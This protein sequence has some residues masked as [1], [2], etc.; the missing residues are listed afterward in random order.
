M[1][2]G[3]N[4]MKSPSKFVYV[5]L[6][7]LMAFTSIGHVGA[8]FADA[9]KEH[10]YAT[11][12]EML[13]MSDEASAAVRNAHAARL[14]L[15]NNETSLAKTEVD[16]AIASL[17]KAEATLNDKLIPD[18]S[19]ADTKPMYLPFDTNM[20]LAETYS[21]TPE[22]RVVLDK[23]TGL[24]QVGTPNEAIDVLR[25][26]GVEVKISTAMLPWETSQT[27]LTEAAKLIGESKFHEA[28][29]ALKAFEEGV[30]V[31]TFG[32]HDIPAQG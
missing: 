19:V 13:R 14:A 6:T 16:K 24:F 10:A 3:D 18:T 25:E 7:T 30:V 26:A 9:S 12:R 1:A 11:Q 29:V 15:F 22:I 28:N 20:A 17:A 27:H 21:V 31:R 5:A 4:T 8:A 32:I 2:K 23:A